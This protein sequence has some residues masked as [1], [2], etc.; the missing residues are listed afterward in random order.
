[1]LTLDFGRAGLDDSLSLSGVASVGEHLF[2]APDEGEKIIRLTRRDTNAYDRPVAYP[3][4][5]LVPLPGAPGDEVDL[6]GL[7]VVDG[8]L[9]CV[10]SHSAVRKRVKRAAPPQKVAEDLAEVTHPAARRVLARIPVDADGS[11]VP[12]V[13]QDGAR[14]ART[15][16][17]LSDAAGRGLRDVLAGDRHVGPFVPLPGK[18]NGLDVEGLVALDGRI[19][20]GLRGPVLRSWAV[21]VELAAVASPAEPR[22]LILGPLR[23]GSPEVHALHFLDL[24]GLGVR[25]LTRVGDDLLILAGPTMVLDGPARILRIARGATSLPLAVHRDAMTQVGADLPP[26]SPGAPR[27]APGTDHAEGITILDGGNGPAVIVYDSPADDRVQDGAIRA[28]VV[29]VG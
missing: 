4:S 19:L 13:P 18:D 5:D 17:S 11:L 29:D 25:D 14:P 1:M 24:D 9:W 8:Y 21:V 10:G 28:D 16:A 27:A 6:E 3:L 22:R 2:L 7:D 26:S 12:H 20:V 15:A 23:T